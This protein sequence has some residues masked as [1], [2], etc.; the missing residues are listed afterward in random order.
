MNF[1]KRLEKMESE[2]KP[3]FKFV[4]IMVNDCE[5]PYLE[6]KKNKKA[7]F[8]NEEQLQEFKDQFEGDSYV[9]SFITH[10]DKDPEALPADPVYVEGWDNEANF[11]L[12]NPEYH[13]YQ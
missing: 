10:L 1:D 5:L 9:Y 3:A 4:M 13:E 2:V 7:F 11:K 6:L 12:S 8:K